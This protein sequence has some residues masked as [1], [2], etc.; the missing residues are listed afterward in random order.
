MTV[1]GFLAIF[2]GLLLVIVLEL[3]RQRRLR[4]R[5]AALWIVFSAGV[6]VAVVFPGS[7]ERIATALGFG[8]PSNLVFVAGL[9][10]LAFVGIQLSVELTRLRFLV[11]RLTNELAAANADEPALG[12]GG[13]NPPMDSVGGE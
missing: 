2:A 13:A 6:V 7:V 12:G 11:E 8:L 4:E 1:V 5:F 10:I 9:I 3:V